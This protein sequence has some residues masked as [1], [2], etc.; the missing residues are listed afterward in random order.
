MLSFASIPYSA[1]VPSLLTYTYTNT[2]RERGGDRVQFS[3]KK[4]NFTYF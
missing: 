3:Q 1:T 4:K 2:H